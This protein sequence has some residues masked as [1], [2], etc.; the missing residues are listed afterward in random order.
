MESWPYEANGNN[1]V[2]AN[3]MTVTRPPERTLLLCKIFLDIMVT[4][5]PLK[6]YE[7]LDS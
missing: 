2:K 1:E 4:P 6:V 5:F 7:N 3:A